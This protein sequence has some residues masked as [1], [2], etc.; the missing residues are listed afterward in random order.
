MPEPEGDPPEQAATVAS[1]TAVARSAGPLWGPRMEY[2]II[3]NPPV[4]RTVRPIGGLDGPATG[5]CASI[6][7]SETLPSG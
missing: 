4:R 3:R 2:R 7:C 6:T 5:T 1:A